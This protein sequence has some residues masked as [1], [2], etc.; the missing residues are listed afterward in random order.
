[1]VTYRWFV[2]DLGLGD[3]MNSQQTEAAQTG[4]KVGDIIATRE[5]KK[6]RRRNSG[7]SS[8]KQSP[9]HR[10]V[11]QEMQEIPLN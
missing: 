2:N 1:M 7:S 11:G 5:I 6:K 10:N 8:G 9:T 3:G 4:P